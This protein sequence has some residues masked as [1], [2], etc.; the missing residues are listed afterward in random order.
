MENAKNPIRVPPVPWPEPKAAW[1]RVHIDFAGPLNGNMYL[2]IVDAYSKWPEIIQMPTVTSSMTINALKRIFSQ[3]G[4]PETLVSDN[5]TQFTSLKFED[6]CKTHSITHL[7]SPPY[8]P[9]SNGQAERFVDTFKRAL[10]KARGEGTT[11]EI[12]QI[13]LL[14]YR[15]TPNPSVKDGISP[16]EALLGRP[17]STKLDLLRPTSDVPKCTEK[18]QMQNTFKKNDTVYV[19]DYRNGFPNWI[20]GVVLKRNG[21]VLYDVKVLG[22]IWTRHKNQLR[23]RLDGRSNGEANITDKIPLEILLD[24]FGIK[25]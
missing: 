12:L 4:F 10:S 1:S 7:K 11:E 18:L 19:R 22:G 14:T 13:F 16:A 15:I 24:T 2:I 5:G 9:Q 23:C 21:S 3:Y 20:D 6:F 25:K 8:H 17:L